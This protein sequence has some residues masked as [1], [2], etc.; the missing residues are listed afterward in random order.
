MRIIH[1]IG[2]IDPVAGGPPQVAVRLAAAQAMLGHEVHLVTYRRA[3]AASEGRTSR[4]LA[5]IPSFESVC[6][7]RLAAPTT[8]WVSFAESSHWRLTIFG[9][10]L[11]LGTTRLA[12][13]LATVA[14]A[15]S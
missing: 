12:A 4:Q 7:H 13:I 9:G 15:T 5:R 3:D 1:V 10:D 14:M 11:T 8:P 2:T 6:I